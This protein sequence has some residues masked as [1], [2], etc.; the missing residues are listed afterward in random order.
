MKKMFLV[1]LLLIPVLAFVPNAIV[2]AASTI[3]TSPT[4]SGSACSVLAP[5]SFATAQAQA[6]PG[7]TINVIGT[8][9]AVTISVSG[10]AEAPITVTSGVFDGAN[11]TA[12]DVVLIEGSYITLT[13]SE[14]KNGYDYGVRVKGDHVILDDVYVHH[15]IRKYWNGTYCTGAGGWGSAVR[16]APTADYGTLQNSTVGFS[17][18]EGVIAL[19]NVGTSIIDNVIRDNYSMNIYLDE[20]LQVTVSGNESR[21]EN[22]AYYRS[23]QPAR[24]IS[25]G[26]E[27]Y[28]NTGTVQ[29]DILDNHIIGC[30]GI[31]LYS[32]NAN[33]K[34]VDSLIDGNVFDTPYTAISFAS[35]TLQNVIITNNVGKGFTV[36]GATASGNFTP[37]PTVFQTGTATMTRTATPTR[38]PSATPTLTATP[39]ASPTP[40]STPIF[41]PTPTQE[42]IYFPGHDQEVCLK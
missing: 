36:P 35:S 41:S 40:T 3:Y 22:S 39:G 24:G 1:L 33:G 27:N 14:I 9:G 37:T 29:A 11:T 20:A 18:G 28:G 25:Y 32:Q 21:C 15:A 30:R 13:N 42:C 2:Q 31:S 7:D 4:G 17:C 16:F 38:T 8:F 12:G 10:T 5:C 34:V 19:A 26:I 23:N 6:V